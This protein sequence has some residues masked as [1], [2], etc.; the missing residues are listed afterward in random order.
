M[1]KKAIYEQDFVKFCRKDLEKE[2]NF[3]EMRLHF[4]GVGKPLFFDF[5]KLKRWDLFKHVNQSKMSE[6]KFNIKNIVQ[7]LTSKEDRK[8]ESEIKNLPKKHFLSPTEESQNIF[9]EDFESKQ[10]HLKDYSQKKKF[11]K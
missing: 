3:E 10:E 1:K 11:K 9:S 5:D 7:I 4:S 2:K 6:K 8:K